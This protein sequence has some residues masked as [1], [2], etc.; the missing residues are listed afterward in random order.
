[1]F[2]YPFILVGVSTLYMRTASFVIHSM[3][4]CVGTGLSEALHLKSVQ[5]SETV[6]KFMYSIAGLNKQCISSLWN[7][8]SKNFSNKFD[9]LITCQTLR[10][11][12]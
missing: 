3:S 9:H 5:Q 8:G 1:M 10:E 2:T 7:T 4:S 6:W 11:N 12:E